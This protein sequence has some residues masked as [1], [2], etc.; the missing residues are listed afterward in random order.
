[1]KFK[2]NKRDRI[3]LCRR[4]VYVPSEVWAVAG[5]QPANDAAKAA[6][7]FG[8][9]SRRVADKLFAGW[10]KFQTSDGEYGEI[11]INWGKMFPQ[12]KW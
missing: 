5:H 2:I 1:M 11:R 4:A 10:K 6:Y 12:I 7:I 9:I 3:S 8:N